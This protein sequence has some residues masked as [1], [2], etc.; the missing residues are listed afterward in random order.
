MSERRGVS[1]KS[2]PLWCTEFGSRHVWLDVMDP[3]VLLIQSPNRSA[4]T[5]TSGESIQG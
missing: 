2:V 5:C 1:Y 4:V 3:Y